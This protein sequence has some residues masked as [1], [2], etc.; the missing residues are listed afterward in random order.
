MFKNIKDI[1][2]SS[3]ENYLVK[4]VESWGG[5]V[6]KTIYKGRRAA[7]DREVILQDFYAKVELKKNGKKPTGEQLRE[8]DKLRK[9]GIRVYV[10]DSYAGVDRLIRHS[11]EYRRATTGQLK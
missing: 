8:H 10:I 1:R 9:L 6:R 5:E 4:Q 11:R 2:E 7:P 3:V